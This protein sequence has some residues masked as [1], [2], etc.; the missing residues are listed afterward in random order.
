MENK[1]PQPIVWRKE[2][3]GF[4]PPQKAWMQHKAVQEKIHEGKKKLA[5]EG[6]LSHAA[7]QRY[8]PTDANAA[9]N[10]DWRSWSASCL[11]NR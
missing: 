11:Y 6:I 2:K 7:L 3:V 1:L 4:E 5:A 8:T 9:T 10:H